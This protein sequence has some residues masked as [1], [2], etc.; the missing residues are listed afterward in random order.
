MDYGG[1]IRHSPAE[2]NPHHCDIGANLASRDEV[3]AFLSAIPVEER[4][5]ERCDVRVP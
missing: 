1:T 5:K 2:E 4:W 3:G